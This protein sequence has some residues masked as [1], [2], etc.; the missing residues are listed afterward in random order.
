M[1]LA[2]QPLGQGLGQIGN[3]VRLNSSSAAHSFDNGVFYYM[4]TFGVFFGSLNLIAL[5]LICAYL[6][7]RRSRSRNPFLNSIRGLTAASFP[8]MCIGLA[9]VNVLAGT[10]GSLAWILAGLG[11][12]KLKPNKA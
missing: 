8:S 4:I 2:E 9:A 6:L 12:A 1:A 5:G 10:A 3:A 11:L 7:L